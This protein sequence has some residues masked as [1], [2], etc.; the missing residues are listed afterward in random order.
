[1]DELRNKQRDEGF[2][3][4]ITC[5]TELSDGTVLEGFVTNVSDTGVKVSGHTAGLAVGEEVRLVLVIHPQQKVA[6]RCEVKHVNPSDGFYGLRFKSDPERLEGASDT[7]VDR[8][9]LNT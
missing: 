8:S 7:R 6:Y 1:M 2:S 4:A 3:P 9:A 5:F